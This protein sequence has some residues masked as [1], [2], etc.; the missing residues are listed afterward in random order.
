MK[1]YLFFAGLILFFFTCVAPCEAQMKVWHQNI[2]Q[3]GLNVRGN[4]VVVSEINAD[5]PES[6]NVLVQFDGICVSAVG[7]LIVLAAS[8]SPDWSI[9]DGN[10]GVEAADDNINTHSFSHTRVYPVSVGTHTFYA[11]AQNYVEE[12]GNGLASIYGTLTVKFFPEK[13]DAPFVRHQGINKTGIN[14]RGSAINLG[15]LTIN[16]PQSGKVLVHFDGICYSEV[17]DRIVLA[18]SNTAGWTPDDGNVGVEAINSDI[19]TNT[20]SHT[21]MYSVAAG[22]NTFYAVA[23]NYVEEDGK[24]I[25]SIYGSLTVEYF[26]DGAQDFIQHQGIAET[27]INV[28]GNPVTVG[29]RGIKV[30]SSG[31][32]VVHFDGSCISS[33]GDRIVLA[34][35]D[36][37]DWSPNDGNVTVEAANIDQNRNSFSHTR[38]YEVTPGGYD[39]Y[40]VTQNY[41][42]TGGTGLA[43]IY[44]SLTVEF[45]TSDLLAHYP[46]TSDAND[47]TGNNGPMELVNTPFQDGGIYCNG[48]YINSGSLDYCH[49]ITPDLTDF[50]FESF[51]IRADFKVTEYPETVRPVFIG[52]TSYRWIGFI[53]DANGTV[54]LKYNN[55]N[56]QKSS[57]T[58]ALNTWHQALITYDGG[59]NTGKL[60]LDGKLACTTEFVLVHG[61]DPDI[62]ITDFSVGKV[63]KGIIKNIMVYDVVQIP[64]YLSNNENSVITEYVLKQNYPNPFNNSTTIYFSLPQSGHVNLAVYDITGRKVSTLV[65]HHL[66]AGEHKVDWRADNL[67]SGIYIYRLN[68]DEFMEAKKLI[69]VK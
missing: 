10:T 55:S 39:F 8:D 24:G 7:D 50:N 25:S 33:V 31:I 45:I 21:R 26:P 56:I 30:S 12:D 65:D 66:N 14:V 27:N 69:I 47:V 42:E 4:V 35:S 52:G 46:L 18:A 17:G 28:R 44:A 59:N 11:V 64:S 32:V 37:P 63:F 16:S 57:V 43:S 68:T 6:G 19:N 40:A 22:N 58:Y 61:T 67:A 41:V 20:F 1:K 54:S 34:A 36:A 3:T 53:L 15:E 62:G 51:S 13:N 29:Q 5:I 38:V 60:Y 9:N 23:Q 48:I 2:S 49:A